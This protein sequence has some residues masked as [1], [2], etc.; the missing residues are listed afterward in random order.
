MLQAMTYLQET[1]VMVAKLECIDLQEC[2][3]PEYMQEFQKV[4]F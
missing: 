2:I 1:M 4:G 3:L